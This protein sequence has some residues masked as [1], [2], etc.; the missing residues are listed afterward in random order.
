[1]LGVGEL[2]RVDLDWALVVAR[3][4][5]PC[6]LGSLWGGEAM[7]GWGEMLVIQVYKAMKVIVMLGRGVNVRVR[8]G[9]APAVARVGSPCYSGS[10][11]LREVMLGWRRIV[12]VQF[13][14]AP[15]VARVQSPCCTGG[16]YGGEAMLGGWEVVRVLL[17]L[18]R[19][20]P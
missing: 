6:S 11:F 7:L 14:W 20:G 15:V 18:R 13:F 16:L 2:D 3:V 17:L 4:E 10:L 9:W 12:R 5:L 8:V 19:G 1:M